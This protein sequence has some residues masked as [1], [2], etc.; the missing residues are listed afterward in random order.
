[1]YRCTRYPQSY[2]IVFQ[3]ML[4]SNQH[5]VVEGATHLPLICNESVLWI[6]RQL[7]MFFSM[8]KMCFGCMLVSCPGLPPFSLPIKFLYYLI[9]QHIASSFVWDPYNT[10]APQ[11]HI[12]CWTK[13]LRP[14]FG[15]PAC[16]E[17]FTL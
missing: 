10:R 17:D 8:V 16:S 11:Q 12:C 14:E 4:A 15:R 1:M 5:V 9:K 3:N 7:A 13:F 6:N 2:E